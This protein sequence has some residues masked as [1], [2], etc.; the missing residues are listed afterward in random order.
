M[1]LALSPNGKYLCAATDASR[2]IIIEVGTSNIVRD[3]YGHKVSDKIFSMN[4]FLFIEENYHAM[5][6]GA[7]GPDIFSSCRMMASVNLELHGQAAENIFLETLRKIVACA[8]G[9]LQVPSLF[10][11]AHTKDNIPERLEIFLEAR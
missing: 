9:I 2:N 10:K 11:R 8:F 6:I 3:L 4:S 1:Q 7:P 5:I